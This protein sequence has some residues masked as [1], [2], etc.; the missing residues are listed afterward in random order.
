[1]YSYLERRGAIRREI[2]HFGNLHARVRN[3][4]I[5]ILC[6]QEVRRPLSDYCITETGFFLICFGGE[7]ALEY[8]GVGFFGPSIGEKKCT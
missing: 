6:L 8:A 7:H 4:Y 2:S 5:Y 3:S 1:M